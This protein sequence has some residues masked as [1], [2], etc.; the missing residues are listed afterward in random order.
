MNNK[1]FIELDDYPI[2]CDPQLCHDYNGLFVSQFLYSSLSDGNNCNIVSEDNMQFEIE[3]YDSLLSRNI[4]SDSYIR[5]FLYYYNNSTQ[6]SIFRPFIKTKEGIPEIIKINKRK[7]RINL[8]IQF[9]DFKALIQSRYIIPLDEKFHSFF[10]GDY[11]LMVENSQKRLSLGKIAS[12]ALPFENIVFAVNSNP[13]KTIELLKKGEINIT[14]HSNYSPLLNS[15]DGFKRKQQDGSLIYYLFVKNEAISKCLNENRSYILNRISKILGLYVD[16]ID[17]FWI[18]NYSPDKISG[19]MEKCLVKE[20]CTLI[21]ADFFPNG[22]LANICADVLKMCGCSVKLKKE[23]SFCMYLKNRFQYDA[24]LG[25]RYP[26]YDSLTSY[27]LSFA[28]QLRPSKKREFLNYFVNEEF[29]GMHRVLQDVPRFFPLAIS[30]TIYLYDNHAEN[31]E[32]SRF[33]KVSFR[34]KKI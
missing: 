31:I 29:M 21:Y 10:S 14:C 11:R 33:G 9:P 22:V 7:F 25:V 18:Q 12:S 23:Q 34:A 17:S 4:F 27:A 6:F 13:I 32:I 8:R 2:A 19:L 26:K 28:T 1:L 15:V 30:K 16:P 24:Y 5:A 20:E 3:L